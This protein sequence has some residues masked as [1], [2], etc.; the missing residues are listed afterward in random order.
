MIIKKQKKR[1]V[2]RPYYS[3]KPY[4]GIFDSTYGDLEMDTSVVSGT[5]MTG[6]VPA[7]REEPYRD[8]EIDGYYFPAE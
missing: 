8:D 6:A 4:S 1:G 3:Q 5:E 2:F 7:A